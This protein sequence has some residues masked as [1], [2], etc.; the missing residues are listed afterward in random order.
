MKVVVGGNLAATQNCEIGKN[1]NAKG[2]TETV[3]IREA[4]AKNNIAPA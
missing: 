2:K 4:L 1:T 3:S